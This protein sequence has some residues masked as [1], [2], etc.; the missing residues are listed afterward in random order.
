M[1]KEQEQKLF[2]WLEHQAYNGRDFGIG[3]YLTLGEMRKY[4][5]AAIEKI[6]R[7]EEV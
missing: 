2:Q 7:N 6:L 1:T 4:L 5:P 3:P